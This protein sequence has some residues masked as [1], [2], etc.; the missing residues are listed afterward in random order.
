MP[1]LS[2]GTAKPMLIEKLPIFGDADICDVARDIYFL[3]H[4]NWGSVTQGMKMPATIKYAEDQIGL[5]SRG[6][7][8]RFL[9]L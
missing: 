4:L 3:T 7:Y 1:L 2:Q 5:V 6:I 9:P 8:S